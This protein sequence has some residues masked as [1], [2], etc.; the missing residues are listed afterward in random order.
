MSR[1]RRLAFGIATVALLITSCV[2]GTSD[3]LDY[4]TE[5]PEWSEP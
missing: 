5:S 3:D 4:E 2:F 1:R